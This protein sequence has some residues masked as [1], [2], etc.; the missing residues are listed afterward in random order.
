MLSS[1]RVTRKSVYACRQSLDTAQKDTSMKTDDFPVVK[2]TPFAAFTT[3]LASSCPRLGLRNEQTCGWLIAAYEKKKCSA[4]GEIEFWTK[5]SIGH[6]VL[7]MTRITPTGAHKS[8]SYT[9]KLNQ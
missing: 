4:C 5:T 9:W 1:G 3:V 2:V 8:G 7:L 6:Q